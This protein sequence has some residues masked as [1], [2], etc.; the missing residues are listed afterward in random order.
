MATRDSGYKNTAS[1]LA[2]LI[3]NSIEAH[4]SLVEIRIVKN[5]P[6]EEGDFTIHVIDDG[7]GM[8]AAEL[9]V[10][11]Q[12]GGSSKFNSRSGLG[13]YGMGLPNSSLSQARRVEV[14]TWTQGASV[15]KNHLDADEIASGRC[16]NI[17]VPQKLRSGDFIRHS[18]SGTIV[19]WCKCDRLSNKNLRILIRNLQFELGRIFRHHLW[20]GLVIKMNEE[21]VLP[22]DPLFTKGG[23]NLIGAEQYGKTLKYAIKIPGAPNGETSDVLVRFVELPVEEWHGYNNEEKAQLMITKRAG[24][25]ILRANREIDYGWFLMG[26]KRKENYD[27]WWRCEISFQPE[28]DELFGVTHTKQE[29]HPTE[30]LKQ[31]LC[32]D[33]EQVARTLT[34]R[35][36][37]KFLDVRKAE[38]VFL[39]KADLESADAFME[40]PRGTDA[41]RTPISPL[42]DETTSTSR[43]RIIKG[44]SYQL[45]CDYS[46]DEEF[47]KAKYSNERME[48]SINKNHPFY[49]KVY[50]PLLE[51]GNAYHHFLKQLE[52]LIFAAARAE[53]LVRD[54]NHK[55]LVNI[56]KENWSKVLATFLS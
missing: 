13:R 5:A 4:A 10:A 16:K 41:V 44:L 45:K 53:T 54:T 56:Y 23:I 28:L 49:D 7:R 30:A 34:H 1:A 26:A 46:E 42:F 51:S 43:K 6:D 11:L 22:I 27:D 19:K 38:H 40:S 8:T 37:Q 14:Y 35:V 52:I 48:L 39:S 47:Y 29:V 12:F 31:M 17:P 24:V 21:I 55:R 20:N 2:E 36:R 33:L 32:P 50:A 25:S 9:N 3:D 15:Y 18:D